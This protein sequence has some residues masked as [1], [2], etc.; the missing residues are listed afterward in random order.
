MSKAP[1]AVVAAAAWTAAFSQNPRAPIHFTYHP[2]DF[3]LDSCET[4]KRHAPDTMAG[5][6]AIFDFNND[7]PDADHL[8]GLFFESHT[9]QQVSYPCGGGQR[10]IPVADLGWGKLSALEDNRL[11]LHDFVDKATGLGRTR[12]GYYGTPPWALDVN[13]LSRNQGTSG[14]K[15][16]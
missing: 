2:I 8:G 11:G 9:G 3:R 4:D 13:A 10:R 15:F 12:Q 14:N 7:L 16:K 5:G 1:W 6:V